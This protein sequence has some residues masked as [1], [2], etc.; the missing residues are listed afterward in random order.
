MNKKE[1]TFKYFKDN[2][3]VV[4]QKESI[5]HYK[6][7]GVKKSVY[8]TYKREYRARLQLKESNMLRLKN[9]EIYYKGRPREKFVFNDNRLFRK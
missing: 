8:L 4:W 5:Q 3:D 2:P 9:P 7:L 1:L 6:K